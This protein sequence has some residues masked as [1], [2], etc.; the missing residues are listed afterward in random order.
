MFIQVKLYPTGRENDVNAKK[1]PLLEAFMCAKGRV[2]A[3]NM[4]LEKVWDMNFVPT[5]SVV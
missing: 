5:T 2:L 3:R 4:L 1:F